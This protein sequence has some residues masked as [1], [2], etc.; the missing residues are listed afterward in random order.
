MTTNNGSHAEG[1]EQLSK[2]VKESEDE[3]DNLTKGK[4]Q[5][6]NSMLLKF[7]DDCLDNPWFEEAF[8]RNKGKK[9]EDAEM[10]QGSK[11]FDK[12]Q[13]VMTAGVVEDG[14]QML[15][16]GGREKH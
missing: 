9:Q 13:G 8:T 1:E 3:V 16:E 11:Y 6:S 10:P 15:S 7:M 2:A 12:L 5:H 14:Q 4:E